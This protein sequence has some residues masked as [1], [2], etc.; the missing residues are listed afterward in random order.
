ML[1]LLVDRD[2]QRL[3][4]LGRRMMLA[5]P[6]ALDILYNRNK[7]LC[8]LNRLPLSFVDDRLRD[9]P[10]ARLFAVIAE[11]SFQLGATEGIHDPLR[12]ERLPP[13]HAHIETALRAEAEAP[14]RR[15]DVM[16]GHA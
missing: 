15:V 8:R 11:N 13:I 7:F 3:K 5:P 12:V 9:P 14:C 2:A 6:A 10:R 1:K 4:D 16:G